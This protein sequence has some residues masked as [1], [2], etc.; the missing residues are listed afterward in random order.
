MMS[1]GHFSFGWL[2][3]GSPAGVGL[4]AGRGVRLSWDDVGYGCWAKAV[5]V[6]PRNVRA[7][8]AIIAVVFKG[9]TGGNFL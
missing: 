9:L 1:Q 6:A 7:R 4:G 3:A 2:K 8:R 5:P